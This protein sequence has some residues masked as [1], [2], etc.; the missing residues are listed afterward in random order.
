MSRID[1]LEVANLGKGPGGPGF[2]PIISGKKNPKGRKV[3]TKT[4]PVMYE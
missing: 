3:D 2:P 4:E 1:S